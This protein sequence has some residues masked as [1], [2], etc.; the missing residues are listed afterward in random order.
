MLA[1]VL[2]HVLLPQPAGAWLCAQEQNNALTGTL[3]AADI[4]EELDE[5]RAELA[6]ARARVAALTE[7]LRNAECNV[8][9][10]EAAEATKQ[11]EAEGA[12]CPGLDE[13]SRAATSAGLKAGA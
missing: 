4:E 13:G 5:Q 6:A 1:G 8:C 9:E 12:P 3:K 10:L 7:Q 2:V 11:P